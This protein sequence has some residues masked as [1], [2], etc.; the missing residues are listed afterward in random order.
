MSSFLFYSLIHYYYNLKYRRGCH[1]LISDSESTSKNTECRKIQFLFICTSGLKIPG[2]YI[3]AQ[4]AIKVSHFDNEVSSILDHGILNTEN[5]VFY[6]NVIH[7]YFFLFQFV[8]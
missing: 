6:F 7:K 1:K 3:K 5:I 4:N 2:L 8:F